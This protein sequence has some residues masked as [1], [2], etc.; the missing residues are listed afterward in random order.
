MGTST[1]L[2]ARRLLGS[3][4][5]SSRSAAGHAAR[6]TC[7]LLVFVFFLSRAFSVLS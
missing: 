1:T 3:L 4:E 5:T 7:F 6:A 2:H